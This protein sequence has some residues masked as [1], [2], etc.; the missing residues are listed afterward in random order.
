MKIAV[1]LVNYNGFSDTVNCID[2]LCN[3]ETPLHII[4]VDNASK[5]DEAALI[6]QKYSNITTFRENKNLGFTGGNNIGIQW[7]LDNGYEYIA[8]LNND[9][10]IDNKL[11]SNLLKWADRDTVVLPYMYYYSDPNSLWYGGGFINRRT[12]NAEHIL[13]TVKDETPFECNFATGCCLL[14]HRDIWQSVGLLN[15]RYFMY[16]EDTEFSIRL[17][18][19]HKKIKIIPS[20]KLWHKVGKSSGGPLSPLSSY[21]VTRNRLHLLKVY[22]DFFSFS[23]YYFT[24]VTRIFWAIRMKLKGKKHLAD[25]FLKGIKDAQ[26]GIMG[27]KDL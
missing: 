14:A 25:A 27:K 19:A 18:K 15:D 24:L 2:S 1:I 23:A 26:K 20:A 6:N 12:G 7:A 4:V 13:K 8:L 3:S 22:K 11:F 9:T 10:V 5:E 21:Y 17:I 16:N